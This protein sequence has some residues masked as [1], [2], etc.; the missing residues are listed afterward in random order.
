MSK[1]F[2]MNKIHNTSNK[3]I[4]AKEMLQNLS[5]MTNTS[6]IN[7][8][9]LFALSAYYMQSH[10]SKQFLL[11]VCNHYCIWYILFSTNFFDIDKISLRNQF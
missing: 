3:C 6:R 9:Y 5:S 7:S 4:T 11:N 8:H 10:Q 1:N 2:D